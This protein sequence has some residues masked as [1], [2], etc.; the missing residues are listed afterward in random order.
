[1]GVFW[2]SSARA[3]LHLC[4]VV[5]SSL[6]CEGFNLVLADGEAAGQ[7]VFHS[8]LHVIPRFLED[9]FGF[10][11]PADYPRLPPRSDLDRIAAEL[12]E[13]VEL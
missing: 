11:F 2:A 12:S 10:R 3:S 9:G 8:H 1:M 6:R 5:A 13:Y 4:P 7:E